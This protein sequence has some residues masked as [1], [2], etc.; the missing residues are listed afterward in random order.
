MTFKRNFIAYLLLCI[1]FAGSATCFSFPCQWTSETPSPN[2]EGQVEGIEDLEVSGAINA[3]TPHPT[4]AD[5]L[6]VGAVNG[7]VWRTENATEG[8]PDWQALTDKMRS[9]SISALEFDLSDAA[10]N[11]LVAGTGRTSSLG[12]FGILA[13]VYKTT[14]SGANWTHLDGKLIEGSFEVGRASELDIRGISGFGDEIVVAAYLKDNSTFRAGVWRSTD[15][16][17]NWSR[18]LAGSSFDLARSSGN[19][20]ILYTNGTN[21]DGNPGIFKSSDHGATWIKISNFQMDNVLGVAENVKIAVGQTGASLVVIA[22]NRILGVFHRLSDSDPWKQLSAPLQAIGG[23]HPGGQAGIHLSVAVDPNDGNIIYIGGD[24]QDRQN[25]FP[26]RGTV[27][28]PP[29]NAIGATDYVAAMARGNASQP[30][31]SQWVHLTHTKNKGFAGGGTENGSA[32]HADSRDMDFAADGVL[33]ESDDGGIFR[34][35]SPADNTGDWFSINGNIQVAEFHSAAW[36]RSSNIII[37]GTQDT[38]TPQQVADTD[39]EARSVAVADG[40]VVAVNS[41]SNGNSIRYSSI[42]GLGGFRRRIYNSS[43]ALLLEEQP[44]LISGFPRFQPLFYTPIK[45]NK[46]NP[47]RILIGGANGVYES[48]NQA[49]NLSRVDT[50]RVNSIKGNPMAYGTD[51][52]EDTAYFGSGSGIFARLS[53]DTGFIQKTG[54]SGG[55]VEDLAVNFSNEDE[56]V[57]NDSENVFYTNDG[58]VTWDNVTGNLV[59]FDAGNL[60]SIEFVQRTPQD[61]IV[62]GADRGVY[63]LELGSSTPP[64]WIDVSGNLPNAMIFHVQHSVADNLLM[65]A[66]L[67]RGAWTMTLPQSFPQLPILPPSSRMFQTSTLSTANDDSSDPVQLVPGVVVDRKSGTAFIMQPKKGI[68][69]I[70]IGSGDT[71]WS[72]EDS[73]KPLGLSSGKLITQVDTEEPGKLKVR[74]LKSD[75]GE[76]V[77]NSDVAVGESVVAS[78]TRSGKTGSFSASAFAEGDDAVR[79]DWSYTANRKS[80]RLT[81]EE[82]ENERAGGLPT[83]GRFRAEAPAAGPIRETI[84]RG[85]YS[86]KLA[87]GKATKVEGTG[88]I[89]AP[90]TNAAPM[91]VPKEQKIAERNSVKYPQTFSTDQKH[92]MVAEPTDGT[93]LSKRYKLTIFEADGKE[94]GAVLAQKSAY[95]FVVVESLLLI[96]SSAYKI[97]VGDKIEEST[98]A[99][100]CYKLADGTEAWSKKI[101]ETN[102]ANAPH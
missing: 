60:R 43:N 26:P 85:S 69:A 75:S 95:P 70:N 39:S 6:F 99:I 37:G 83:A 8:T 44:S 42:Q 27:T 9:L 81:V 20:Q 31:D 92:V 41:F 38:G 71:T 10:H 55:E 53:N 12:R 65:A 24:R 68:S 25:G 58:G 22:S 74:I 18:T 76:H 21:A 79:L 98:R 15:N 82:V 2:T 101:R 17:D 51:D 7:G 56:C 73:D 4:D 67:G 93:D 72:T 84:V 102:L 63:A 19:A 87:D 100:V 86:V 5:V 16:G 34:R 64:V 66:T 78:V 59:S 36:D 28:P 40:G 52:N 23:I 91:M 57:A 14:D 49:D 47:N 77:A 54:Y 97:R 48:F 80:G 45:I 30:S 29:E 32:P 88:R 90:K 89:A 1:P 13:G 46:K 50:R 33:L 96:E 61:I 35:T 94:V 62:I 11:T 3:V